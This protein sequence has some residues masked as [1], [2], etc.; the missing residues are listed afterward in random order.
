M[1]APDIR[2]VLVDDEQHAL[3]DL[4]SL[5]ETFEAVE[6]AAVCKNPTDAV[7]IVEQNT[8]DLL[9]LDIQMPRMD[10]FQ[11]LEALKPLYVKPHVI[12]TTSYD[13]YAIK[14]IRY[15]VFDYLLKPL[16][17]EELTAAIERFK[18]KRERSFSF[19]YELRKI[20]QELENGKKLKFNSCDGI[21][22]YHK[23]EIIYAEAR[24][25]YS[26]L[27]FSEGRK[28]Y[29]SMNLGKLEEILTYPPFFRLSRSIIINT[30][31]LMKVDKKKH[32]CVL[33]NHREF[34]TLH[35]P[36]K[37]ISELNSLL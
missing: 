20:K 1:Q 22:F 25:S 36:S 4:I 37:K 15:A 31:Y 21:V 6:I 30:H 18:Q 33:Q 9:F 32:Q 2:V 8:P 17:K 28:Q 26:I 34:Y 12:F 24:R 29:L 14:A 16:Q 13:E 3:D 10:G 5:L 19:N 23:D 35:I 7:K 11:V 27:F